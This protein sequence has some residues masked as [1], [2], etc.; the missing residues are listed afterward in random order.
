MS[1]KQ[2]KEENVYSKINYSGKALANVGLLLWFLSTVL[3]FFS[4][5]DR[6]LMVLPLFGILMVVV[7]S[8]IHVFVYPQAGKENNAYN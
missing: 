3:G 8:F 1:R 4:P 7:G 6:I 2:K 5:D